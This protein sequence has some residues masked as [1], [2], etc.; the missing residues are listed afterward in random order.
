MTIRLPER[1]PEAAYARRSTARRRVGPN[2]KCGCGEIRPESLI[3]QK[4]RV[5]CFECN[6]KENNVKNEDDHHFAMKANSPVTIPV[7]ANDHAAELNAA[8][9]DWPKQTRQNPDGSP[10]IAAAGCIRGFIDTILYLINQ[11]LLWVADMLEKADAFLTQKF[12]KR[13]WIGTE[14]EQFVPKH[15]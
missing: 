4:K 14:I 3:R 1:D 5:I 9:Q 6:R 12:G 15:K 2:A 7:P 8:Q 10:L 13:W 11:G